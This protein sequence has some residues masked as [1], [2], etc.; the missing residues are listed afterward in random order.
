[1]VGATEDV[2]YV[3]DSLQ[4]GG[5]NGYHVVG[6]TLLDRNAGA[7]QDRGEHLP[8]SWAISTP[9][10]PRRHSSGG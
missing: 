5:E 10:P 9:S 6:T 2:E 7:P 4:K 3:I 8:R 1:M